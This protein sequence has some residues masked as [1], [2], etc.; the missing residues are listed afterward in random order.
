MTPAQRIE[1]YVRLRDYK[2]KCEDDFKKAMERTNQ[3]MEKL[4]NE[5]LQDLETS[6]AQSLACGSGTAY[7]SVEFSVSVEDREAFMKFVKA[8]SWDAIDIKA[9]KSFVRDCLERGEIVPGV[10][11]TQ[12]AKV[13]VRR[14]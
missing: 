5:L 14:S 4:G 1:A 8:G 7:K 11:T 2:K 6:G 10:K 13:G 3:A 9:N 12:F